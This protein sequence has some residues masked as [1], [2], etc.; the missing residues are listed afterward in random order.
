MRAAQ[1]DETFAAALRALLVEQV[2]GASRQGSWFTR[3]KRWMG[4]AG[5]LLVLAAGGGGIAYATG[6]FTTPPGG[7]LVTDLA[8]PITV[9]GTGTRTVQLGIQ[10]AGTNAIDITFTCLSAG[11]FTFADGSSEVCD[12]ADTGPQTS[13]PMSIAPGQDSTTITATPGARWRLTA[14]YATVTTT[15][16]GV[17]AN[18]QTYGTPNQYGTPDLV[19][20]QATN[21][22]TGYVY[23]NQLSPPPP[24]TIGQALAQTN[25]PPRTLTVYQS[26]GK[27][28]IGEF[29]VDGGTVVTRSA[30]GSSSTATLSTTP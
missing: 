3:R 11:T 9:T 14:A 10:P 29:V 13:N 28:P 6:A 5:A 1:M 7:N 16:W 12:S 22:R 4:R 15:A 18:G 25:A 24:K 19:A 30:D 21:G 2:Q 8:A 26:D 23:A 20:A 17:N 27:T